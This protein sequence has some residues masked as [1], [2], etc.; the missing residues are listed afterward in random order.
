MVVD[1]S[2][3]I[4]REWRHSREHVVVRFVPSGVDA[5][6][7]I[8][9]LER[10]RD[11]A[12]AALIGRVGLWEAVP[13]LDGS[14]ALPVN[15]CDTEDDLRTVLGLLTASLEDTGVSGR[16]TELRN[17]WSVFPDP[18]VDTPSLSTVLCLRLRPGAGASDAGALT[19]DITREDVPAEIMQAV[20]RY[21]LAWCDVPAGSHYAEYGGV[22][23]RLTKESLP[24]LLAAALRS[25]PTAPA[26]HIQ[27]VDWPHRARQVAF[28]RN[29]RVIFTEAAADLDESWPEVLRTATT[30]LKNNVP[31]S[32]YG[33][34]VRSGGSPATMEMLLHSS[35]SG[36]QRPDV[37]P[38]ES[39]IARGLEDHLAPDA[40]AVQLLGPRYDIA[41]LQ[42]PDSWQLEALPG[43]A[44]L[45]S[46]QDPAAWVAG[47]RPDAD[48]LASGRRALDPLL[49][50]RSV[51]DEVR[52][53]RYGPPA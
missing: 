53:R 18:L 36:V 17:D 51:A 14:A 27:C 39:L 35:L 41:S 50:Q 16:L 45:L 37:E 31:T 26:I 19:A 49:L 7:A 9:A 38:N 25:L 28:S 42:L 33:F 8:S 23:L 40:F 30:A 21:A 52:L 44:H 5:Q 4:V 3:A 47:R 11:S 20:V 24:G 32:D 48:V 1:V 13:L 46:H 34:V 2:Q 22:S 12:Q 15:F 10:A 43:G 29:A 6:T